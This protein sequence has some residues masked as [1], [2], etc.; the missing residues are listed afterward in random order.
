[1]SISIERKNIYEEIVNITNEINKLDLIDE[2]V[3][4]SKPIS[5]EKVAK[6]LH[7]AEN[8]NIE[9]F[10]SRISIFIRSFR[11]NGSPKI[12]GKGDEYY[13]Y[14]PKDI[15]PMSLLILFTM[16]YGRITD[17]EIFCNH[18]QYSDSLEKYGYNNI[19]NYLRRHYIQNTSTLENIYLIFSE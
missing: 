9:L 3:K 15:N 18:N 10:N 2:L 11:M 8:E 16:T 19:A 13:Q 5:K 4:L 17:M 14:N 1:M 12:F 7:K 6:I